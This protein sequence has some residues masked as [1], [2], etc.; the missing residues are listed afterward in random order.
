V[1]D[2]SS[3]ASVETAP[4][5]CVAVV[6]SIV[7]AGTDVGTKLAV[8]SGAIDFVVDVAL[9]LLPGNEFPYYV[10]EQKFLFTGVLP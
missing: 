6:D 9:A 4:E 8:V 2:L 10:L 1:H 7:R 3:P 5:L